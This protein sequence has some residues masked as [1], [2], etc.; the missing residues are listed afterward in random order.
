[1]D[2][3]LIKFNIYSIQYGKTKNLVLYLAERSRQHVN[4]MTSVAAG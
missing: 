1:M 3:K 2:V 4:N